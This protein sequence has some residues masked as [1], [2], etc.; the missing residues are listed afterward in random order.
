MIR[1][2]DIEAVRRVMPHASDMQIRRHLQ[3]RAEL[4]RQQEQQ[5]RERVAMALGSVRR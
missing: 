3:Q 4:V 1:P 5:Q 2:A